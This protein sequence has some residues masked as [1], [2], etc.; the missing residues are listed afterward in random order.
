[1]SGIYL[2]FILSFEALASRRITWRTRVR[3]IWPRQLFSYK[4]HQSYLIPIREIQMKDSFQLIDENKSRQID[5]FE[6]EKQLNFRK[7][8]R[9]LKGK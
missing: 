8:Y 6:I 2:N 9:F 4:W 7:K 5:E 1:M 3:T